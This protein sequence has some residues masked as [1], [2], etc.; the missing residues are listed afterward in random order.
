MQFPPFVKD[1]TLPAIEYQH[2]LRDWTKM[3]REESPVI[4]NEDNNT[5]VV[6]RYNDVVYVQNDYENFSSQQ[7]VKD[8][9]PESPEPTNIIEMDPPQHRQMRSLLTQSFSPRAIA[10]REPQVQQIV[11]ELFDKALE[12]GHIDW[13]ADLANPL[14]VIVIAD[15]LGLPRDNWRQFKAWTDAIINKTPEIVSA[16]E[17]FSGFFIPAIEERQQHPQQDIL[18]GLIATEVEGRRLSFDELISFCHLLFIAGNITT[19]NMLG[20]AILSF[21]EQPQALAQLRAH[22]ELVESAVEEIL[23]YMPP[24]RSGPNDL[25]LGRVVTKDVAIG[26]HQIHKGERIEVSRFAANFDERQFAEPDRIDITRNPNRHQSFGHGIHFC[27]GAPL[28]RLEMKVVFQTLVKRTK[29]ITLSHDQ[30]IEQVPSRLI[31]GPLRLPV[32]LQPA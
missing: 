20:N 8:R 29:D 13:M 31:F 15:M 26:R 12:R 18:S 28:A 7:T 17:N 4:Y 9:N 23:R 16:S 22:P 21:D 11:D 10:A 25:L 3:M 27:I 32:T 1:L 30:K 14:P 19:S 6:F 24:F 2:A 5:W